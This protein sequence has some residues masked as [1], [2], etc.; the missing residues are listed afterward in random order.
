MN[1]IYDQLEEAIVQIKADPMS[2][3]LPP[4]LVEARQRAEEFG[5]VVCGSS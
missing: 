2:E 5:M 4:A 1:A 3:E